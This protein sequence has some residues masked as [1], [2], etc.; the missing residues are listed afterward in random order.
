MAVICRFPIF[1]KGGPK[2]LNQVL[3]SVLLI[4]GCLLL[5]EAVIH[6]AA[7]KRP[8]ALTTS[9]GM[10]LNKPRLPWINDRLNQTLVGVVVFGAVALYLILVRGWVW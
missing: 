5:Y 7:A 3:V 8:A 2:M 10:M 4:A 6:T 1:L 9:E